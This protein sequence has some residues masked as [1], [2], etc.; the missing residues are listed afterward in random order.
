MTTA[1]WR[2]NFCISMDDRYL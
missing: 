2:T 1:N